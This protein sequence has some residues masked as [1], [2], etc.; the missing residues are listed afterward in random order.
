[1]GPDTPI[2]TGEN[3]EVVLDTQKLHVFDREQEK[4]IV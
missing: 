2:R 3:I 1:M 4:A